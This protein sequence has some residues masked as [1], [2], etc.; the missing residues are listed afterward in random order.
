MAKVREPVN[1]ENGTAAPK[2]CAHGWIA[3]RPSL[4]ESWRSCDPR[5]G[6]MQLASDM[7]GVAAEARA[8]HVRDD[9]WPEV[10]AR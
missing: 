10:I 1:S 2:D 3:V 9:G 5:L 7:V 4:A 6:V 8:D